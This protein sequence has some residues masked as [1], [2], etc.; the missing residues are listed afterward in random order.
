MTSR[1]RERGR[2]G[3]SSSRRWGRRRKG[4]SATSSTERRQSRRG[5]TSSSCC[6]VSA[7]R[8]CGRFSRSGRRGRS[9]R[10]RTSTSACRAFIIRKSWLRNGS[11][12]RSPT[13]PR[14][15]AYSWPGRDNDGG[16]PFAEL[17][18]VDYNRRG[19][20]SRMPARFDEHRPFIRIVLACP[21]IVELSKEVFASK[22]EAEGEFV[23]NRLQ[24]DRDRFQLNAT[25]TDV[26][27]HDSSVPLPDDDMTLGHRSD[28]VGAVIEFE[29]RFPR[30]EQD[31]NPMGRIFQIQVI[32]PEQVTNM[33]GCL[34]PCFRNDVRSLAVA[35]SSVAHLVYHDS[36]CTNEAS[37]DDDCHVSRK[38]CPSII[39][40]PETCKTSRF[41]LKPAQRAS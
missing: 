18:S 38:E 7:R 35:T 13:R 23:L 2:S 6:R 21:F 16:S 17:R 40:S 28:L 5:S 4:S 37:F 12:W 30:M 25:R 10:S 31:L 14:S 29:T 36:S 34:C 20:Q 22:G 27:L 3:R 41:T 9:S 19:K 24:F 26:P 39:L 15:T 8:R 11:R 32:T 33:T 1:G